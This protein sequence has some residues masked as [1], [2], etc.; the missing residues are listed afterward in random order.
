MVLCYEHKLCGPAALGVRAAA[1][2]RPLVMTNG[3]FDLLHAGHVRYLAQARALGASLLVAVNSDASVRR[4]GKGPARPLNCCEDRM[5]LLAALASTSLLTWIDNETASHLIA[6]IH[7][8]WYV[9]GGDY[10]IALTDEGEAARRCGTRVQTL[11]FSQGYS[12]SSIIQRIVRNET[13]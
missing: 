10:D 1:L 9:K 12:T 6:L 2:P 5:T 4:L 8:D 13:H 7:P 3:V 11:E